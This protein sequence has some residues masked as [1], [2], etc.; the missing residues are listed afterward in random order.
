MIGKAL[1]R[2]RV[3][4]QIGAGAMGVV[5]RA[6]DEKLHRD[7]AVKVLPAGALAD[8]SARKRFR[9]EALTLSSLNHPHIATIYDFHTQEGTDFLVMEYVEGTT[10]GAKLV[11]G[12]L[13]EKEV[14]AIGIQIAEALEEA[15][16]RGVIHRDLK[17][18]NIMVTPKGHV[19]VLDFGLAKLLRPITEDA[20][21]EFKSEVHAVRGTLPYMSPEQ[22]RGELIDAVSDIHALGAILYEMATGRRPF[23]DE[24]A[25]RLIDAILHQVPVPPSLVNHRISSGLD[26]IALKALEK[27]PSHRYQSAKEVAVDLTRLGASSPLLTYSRPYRAERTR[28][29]SL[30]AILAALLAG[31]ALVGLGG[32]RLW[33]LLPGWEVHPGRTTMGSPI[34]AVL[35]LDN[36][37]GDSTIDHLGLGIAH[38]LST[39]LSAISSVTMV[40]PSATLAYHE[41]QNT[42]EIARELGATFVVTGSVQR[43]GS[44]LHVTLNVVRSDNSIAWGDASEGSLDDLFGLQR[45]LARGLS[46]ALQLMMTPE[47]RR[48]LE[49]PPTRDKQAFGDYMQ[50]RAFLERPDVPGNVDRA[51]SLFRA[52]IEKD[53][54]FAL[55]HA[56]LGDAYWAMYVRTS[57]PEWTQKARE[58][59]M[60]ALRLDPN[61]AAVRYSLALIYHGT[62][63]RDEAVEELERALELQPNSDD[64]HRLLGDI[65]AS[66]GRV[67]EAIDQYQEAIDIRPNFWGNHR[68]LGVAYYRASRYEKAVDSFRRVT[69]LQ[70]DLPWGFQILGLAYHTLGDVERAIANYQQAIT[71]GPSPASYSNLGTIHY[72]RGD[73]AA[74]ARQY[75][76]ALE[77]RP[78]WP[79]THRNLGDALRRLGRTEEARTAYL[80]ALALSEDLLR[81]NPKDAIAMSMRA[82]YEAKLGRASEAARHAAEALEL[83]PSDGE[84]LYNKS[85]VHALA[86]ETAEAMATL[87][88]ALSH[89]YSAREASHDDDLA[90]LRKLPRFQK[91]IVSSGR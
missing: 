65:L 56:G 77:L 6:R 9:Q 57:E 55:A 58:A 3:I 79:T 54:S 23:P 80:K 5:Y 75:E 10:L 14:A 66:E 28:S 48:R 33:D 49:T 41:E 8:E 76:R 84:V 1:D 18:G 21:T 24:Q 68:A 63:R 38:T 81:V 71:L 52:A 47:D 22:L 78:N 82:V 59:T 39:S 19:K 60:E 89:G 34:V 45:K 72:R 13:P 44:R 43:A 64:A 88:E 37:S 36:V 31:G 26:S 83:A 16:E 46:E 69:E 4:E 87:E 20:S 91:L 15:H 30:I 70:P 73:F 61:Q 7:V 40:S 50:A 67:D 12:P 11:R 74:A 90:A 62:G 42:G 51:L 17:P 25:P 27:E 32:H 53:P 86:G 2:Y 85:V 35:P 29:L